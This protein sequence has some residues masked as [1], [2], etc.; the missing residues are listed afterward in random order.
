ME[1]QPSVVYYHQSEEPAPAQVAPVQKAANRIFTAITWAILIV[2]L[3]VWSVV[4][5]LFWIPLML[6]AMFRFSLSLVQ[7]V[8]VGQRPDHA[9]RI[10]RDSVSFYRRGF[11]VAIETVTGEEID[12]E[13]KEDPHTGNRLL[14]ELLWAVPVWYLI[15]FAMGWVQASPVDLWNWFLAIQWSEILGSLIDWVRV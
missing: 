1:Y 10:L 14:L 15:F 11:V 6:R 8:F 2:V 9:A 13:T 12:G 3:A 7:S 4:G 5:A